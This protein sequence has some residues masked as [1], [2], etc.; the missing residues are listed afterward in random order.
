MIE[1][2]CGSSRLYGRRRG[3]SSFVLALIV[4]PLRPPYVGAQVDEERAPVRGSLESHDAEPPAFGAFEPSLDLGSQ[5]G[6]LSEVAPAF[7]G[8]D[9]DSRRTAH[10]MSVELLR[11]SPERVV[12]TE[13]VEVDLRRIVHPT[14][15]GGIAK[16]RISRHDVLLSSPNLPPEG[17]RT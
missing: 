4:P 8:D 17:G 5:H 6:L 16:R 9:P 11:H 7:A 12:G 2:S 3:R 15:V 14:L 1:I 10:A 13:A